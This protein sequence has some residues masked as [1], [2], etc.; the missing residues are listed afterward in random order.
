MLEQLHK[1]IVWSL[2]NLASVF[3]ERVIGDHTQSF[4]DQ[5]DIYISLVIFL[6][7]ETQMNSLFIQSSTNIAIASDNSYTSSG[8]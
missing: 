6:L 5:A 3:E 2:A 4:S 7:T 1:E 8:Q